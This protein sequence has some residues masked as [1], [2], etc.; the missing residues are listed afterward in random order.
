MYFCHHYCDNF[1]HFS[2][3]A[4]KL[5]RESYNSS[6]DIK[7]QTQKIF[8]FLEKGRKKSILSIFYPGLMLVGHSSLIRDYTV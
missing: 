8:M 4:L 2:S 3:Y 5:Y 1:L 6:L 7:G